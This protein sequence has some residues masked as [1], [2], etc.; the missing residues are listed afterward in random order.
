MQACMH[1]WTLTH[2]HT[3]SASGTASGSFYASLSL[4]F[5][6]AVNFPCKQEVGW[7]T[8]RLQGSDTCSTNQ[9]LKV[10][11]IWLCV[12]Q[13]NQIFA[14]LHLWVTPD[15]HKTLLE[16]QQ[17]GKSTFGRSPSIKTRSKLGDDVAK[18]LA[19]VVFVNIITMGTANFVLTRWIVKKKKNVRD[20]E[21]ARKLNNRLL[22]EKFLP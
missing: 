21:S 7:Q 15:F 22:G 19:Y 5:L 4:S 14:V 2:T 20:A 10:S 18:L 9:A 11:L 8:G 1:I 6:A 16:Y 3:H 17:R 13:G 12:L